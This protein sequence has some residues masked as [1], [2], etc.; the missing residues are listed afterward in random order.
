MSTRLRHRWMAAMAAFTVVVTL[1]F[2]LLAMAFVY[3]VEDR[4]LER[5]LR[6]EVQRQQA[7]H[8]AHG[9]WHEPLPEGLWIVERAQDLPADLSATL[10]REPERTEVAGAGGR[11]YHLVPLQQAGRAPWLVAEVSG[12]LIVR[13]L[14]AALL[15]WLAGWGGLV[16]L[17]ALLLGAWLARRVTTPL[18]TLA[19]RVA[20]AD[21]GRLPEG[22]A[23]GLGDDEVGAVGRAFDAL[24][25]RTRDFVAREQA[26]TRDASHELRT[27]L[28]VLRLQIERLQADPAAPAPLRPQLAALHAATLLMQ[29]TVETL[30]LMA[31]EPAGPAGGPGDAA[32]RPAAPVPVLPL[33]ERWVMAHATWLDHQALQL[34]VA[35]RRDDTIALP[36][37]VLQLALASLLGNAFAHGRPGGCV[38]LALVD[39]ALVVSNPGA[40]PPPDATAPGI[41]G[42][43]SSGFG[44]GLAILQRLLERHGAQLALAHADGVMRASVAVPGPWQP[45]R[46]SAPASPT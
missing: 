8:Q 19:R 36:E 3:T 24:L 41:R 42:E 27:P 29:Q 7:H 23:Q 9:R 40:A 26:F 11:H 39:G 30:L 43:H 22:V 20:G 44:L 12:Q 33:A 28:A 34:Q 16:V 14:R 35:L 37:P 13:P 10:R 46:P 32:A 6:A 5:T 1:L 17:L 15:A 38:T 4:F 21:P 2:A 25:A 45:G 18:E 31:R